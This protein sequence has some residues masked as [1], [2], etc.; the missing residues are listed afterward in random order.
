MTSF[1]SRGR[2][3]AACFLGLCY[4]LI[5]R[6]DQLILD[7]LIVDGSLCVGTECV[8]GEFDP[9][10][11]TNVIPFDTL[12]I[13]DA[14][15]LI[16]FDDT[17]VSAAFPSNDWL[18]GITDDAGTGAAYFFITDESSGLDVLR[19]QATETGGVALGAGSQVV[20][21]AISV[22][23]PGTERAIVNVAPG[24]DDTDAVNIEQF[25]A[26]E[27]QVQIDNAAAIGTLDTDIADVQDRIDALSLR[28]D[29][30]MNR[31]D[32]L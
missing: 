1:L 3:V 20:P 9:D 28:L 8:D 23:A 6:A 24:I 13:K 22:G 4:S 5:A 17:S 18:M 32:A 15:P 19:M 30:L 11:V 29:D 2:L 16:R 7:D 10:P 25:A 12:K 31:V 14:E 27:A 26:F 21:G